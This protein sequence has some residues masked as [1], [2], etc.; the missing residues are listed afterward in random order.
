[1][2]FPFHGMTEEEKQE[3]TP[4]IQGF[5]DVVGEEITIYCA[6]NLSDEMF[7]IN[8]ARRTD[9]FVQFK[10]IYRGEE[11]KRRYEERIDR[12]IAEEFP[13]D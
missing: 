8:Y 7:A 4:Y 5:K 12:E 3:I 10:W 1:M 9:E 2:N 13:N 6:Y 11:G